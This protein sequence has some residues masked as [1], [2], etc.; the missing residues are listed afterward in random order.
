MGSK[1]ILL[2][3]KMIKNK[4]NGQINLSIPK[5]KVCKELIDKA[6]SGKPIKLLFED[7]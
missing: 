3:L 5:K 2:K 4:S 7:D 1:E 6:Y